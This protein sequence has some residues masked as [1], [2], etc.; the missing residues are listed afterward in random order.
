MELSRVPRL[1]GRLRAPVHANSAVSFLQKLSKA[2]RDGDLEE[3][4][5]AGVQLAGDDGQNGGQAC[6]TAQINTDLRDETKM[7]KARGV[8]LAAV[9]RRKLG[10]AAADMAQVDTCTNEAGNAGTGPNP[11]AIHTVEPQPHKAG[12]TQNSGVDGVGPTAPP[13]TMGNAGGPTSSGTADEE[14]AST[15]PSNL[16]PGL[17]P[18]K[19]MSLR[20]PDVH[21]TS[22]AVARALR[23]IGSAKGTSRTSRDRPAASTSH[24]WS[25]RS[26]S[27][28]P[29]ER[30][31]WQSQQ[32][33]HASRAAKPWLVSSPSR[34]GS[35]S[36][37]RSRSLSPHHLQP[38]T[39]ASPKQR[40]TVIA[41]LQAQT[42]TM[43]SIMNEHMPWMISEVLARVQAHRLQMPGLPR[44]VAACV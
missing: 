16:A 34:R 44:V 1:A 28:S 14:P 23:T 29:Q 2:R 37:V 11:S 27:H 7:E 38:Q 8:I 41:E 40:D 24:A 42:H 6:E 36:P 15:Q 3:Q 9:Q 20:M 13:D 35:T 18:G 19:A 10:Q 26:V 17:I 32:R 5:A 30:R 25:V 31:T 12:E 43:A 4:R 33:A 21:A 22:M 39:C